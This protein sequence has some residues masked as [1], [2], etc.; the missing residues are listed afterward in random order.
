M[1]RLKDFLNGFSM[2]THVPSGVSPNYD[3]AMNNLLNSFMDT[4]NGQRVAYEMG[5]GDMKYPINQAF[6]MF[7]A[8]DKTEKK[9]TDFGFPPEVLELF[10]KMNEG[11]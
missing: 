10:L 6:A 11:K 1:G 2:V 9:L 3:R 7:S 5:T 4:P 8:A